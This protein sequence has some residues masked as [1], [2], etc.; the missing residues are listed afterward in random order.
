MSFSFLI[1]LSSC[2]C[3]TRSQKKSFIYVTSYRGYVN[4]MLVL[5]LPL[6]IWLTWCLSDFSTVQFLLPSPHF[7]L[8]RKKSL[9]QVTFRCRDDA[10]F[11]LQWNSYINLWNSS[12]QICHLFPHLWLYTWSNLCKCSLITLNIYQ[13]AM[14]LCTGVDICFM[15]CYI[16]NY[17]I[18]LSSC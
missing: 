10:L 6:F 15:I 9:V 16:P 11:S 17:F 8:F 1:K 5:L 18:P 7:K 3:R 4:V 12:T 14:I 13:N 2:V